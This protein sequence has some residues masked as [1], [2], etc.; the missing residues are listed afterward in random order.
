MILV[1]TEIFDQWLSSLRD[2]RARA[3][4]GT[5]LERL[6]RGNPGQSRSVGGGVFELK[7]D[8]GPGYRVY[9][10]QRGVVLIVLLC[11]GDK[12]TQSSD[13][14]RAKAIASAPLDFEE[15]LED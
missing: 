3:R 13:I 4:I 6:Y 9:Y 1:R 10:V 8:Y 2:G 5:R 14:Q 7:I 11:G 15:Q 12:T